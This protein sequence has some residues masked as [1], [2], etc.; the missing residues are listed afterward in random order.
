MTFFIAGTETTSTVITFTL[1]E[2]CLNPRIQDKA[3]LEIQSIIDEKGLTYEST[4]EM[5]FLDQCILGR[6][7]LNPISQL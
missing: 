1:Y 4:N 5:T 7:T 2:L 3:R 6:N